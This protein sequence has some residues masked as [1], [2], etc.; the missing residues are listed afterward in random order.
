MCF[1][2]WT[3]CQLVRR[4]DIAPTKVCW[5]EAGTRV[6]LLCSDASFILTHDASAIAATGLNTEGD[7]GIESAFDFHSELSDKITSG[8]WIVDTFVYTNASQRLQFVVA[9]R[10][11]TVAHLD[12]QYLII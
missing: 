7:D 2:L 5:N 11:E 6:A 12:K 10:F 8:V 4:I 3:E 9:G 1:Y